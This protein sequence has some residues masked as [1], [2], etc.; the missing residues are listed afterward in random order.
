MITIDIN[1][2]FEKEI[3]T[4]LIKIFIEYYLKIL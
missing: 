3:F 2:T 1:V 4:S